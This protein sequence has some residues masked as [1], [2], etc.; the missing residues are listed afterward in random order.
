MICA[1]IV[2]YNSNKVFRCFESIKNQVDDIVI[3][4]NATT[5]KNI[6]SKLSGLKSDKCKLIFNPENFGIATALNQGVKYAKEKNATWVLTLDDDSEVGD[7]VVSNMMSDYEKLSDKEKNKVGILALN[8]VERALIPLL[9]KEALGRTLPVIARGAKCKR[10]IPQTIP[11]PVIARGAKRKRAIPKN[12]P[13]CAVKY[14]LTSGNFIKTSMFDICGNFNEN[15]FIDQVDNDFD[16][17][18]RKKGFLI[19]Q[20]QKNF[21]LHELGQSQKKHGF[22]IR[23]YSPIRRYYLT[24]NCIYIFKKHFFF[25]CV[26]TTRILIG[27]ILGGIFKVT[28]FEPNK[29]QKLKSILKG[30]HDA[31]KNNFGKKAF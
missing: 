19:L 3:I 27:A 9:Q 24:R 22:T 13:Y 30:I 16:F 11:L 12:I 18:L 15:L 20:S 8:Y 7:G 26:A 25:D 2:S 1:I 28:F 6:I 23:N 4:D 10:V 31:L 21:I 14:A 17:R 29:T 5:D